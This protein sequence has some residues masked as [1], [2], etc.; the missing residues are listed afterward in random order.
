MGLSSRMALWVTAAIAILLLSLGGRA[1]VGQNPPASG[2]WWGSAEVT[3]DGANF[4]PGLWVKIGGSYLGNVKVVSPT[5]I[6][7]TTPHASAGPY[8]L[9]VRNPGQMEATLW[10][11]YRYE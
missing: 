10:R 1:L 5:R 7:G 4:L 11:A 6:T 2:P 9:L 3:I 8:D